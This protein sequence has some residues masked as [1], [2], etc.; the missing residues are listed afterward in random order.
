M[1]RNSRKLTL[2]AAGIAALALTLSACSSG[3]EDSTS[4]GE[5]TPGG[6]ASQTVDPNAV[7]PS[8][9]GL[10]IEGV[11]ATAWAAV[12]FGAL[13]LWDNGTAWSQIELEKGVFKWDNLDGAIANANSKGMTDILMVLGTTPEWAASEK[14]DP[15]TVYPPYPGANTAPANFEDWDTWVRTVATK[16]K[17]QLTSYQIWNEAS[18]TSF[19]NGTPEQ[20][21]ELTDRAYKIIK[22]IDPNAKVVSASPALRL[23]NAYDKFFPAYLAALAERNWPVDVIAVHTYPN[24]EGDPAARGELIAMARAAITAA[25]APETLEF[26]DTELNY[27]LAGPGPDR[28]R[29]DITGERAAGFVVR[30]YIDNLRY[31]IDRSYWYIYTQQ[32][33]DL[34]G[35]QAFPGSESE[36]GFFALDNWV[37]G[38]SFEECTEASGAVNCTFSKDGTKWLVS[39]AQS[40]EVPLVA[41]AGSQL[42]CD[43]LSNCQELREG[44]E[45]TLTEVPVRI[46][47]Q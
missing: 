27:G 4:G 7:K 2:A 31:G 19:W 12:P 18:Y 46:Y 33:Y 13:R 22:E 45:F 15:D 6:D 3:G 39:W 25:G 29:Q 5:A 21:A 14:T 24:A 42:V 26:W 34:L 9:V 44:Q 23:K 16:Y 40:G 35:V 37:L 10:H 47:L 17:G 38:A 36:Q 1:V 30:T 11:E 43:P 41:P 32:P 20:M 8:L 28:P